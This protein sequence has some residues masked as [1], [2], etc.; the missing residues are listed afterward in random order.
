MIDALEQKIKTHWAVFR[1]GDGSPVAKLCFTKFCQRIV[2]EHTKVLFLV[3]YK[4]KPLCVLKI[5][6]S[7]SFNE[8]LK[9]EAT[10]QKELLGEGVSTISNV[11][12]EDN[13]DGRYLYAEEV[14]DGVPLSKKQAF[15]K[16]KE[17]VE[18]IASFPS[19][20]EITITAAAE[21]FEK[22]LPEGDERVTQ[23]LQELQ[24]TPVVL[25]TGLTHSD[26][27]RPNILYRRGQ[28]HIIDWERAGDRPFY[29]IDAVYFMIKL[30]RISGSDDW[31]KRA[32][33]IF[34]RY[35]GL[36][37]KTANALYCIQ[38]LFH[39]TYKH[40]PDVYQKLIAAFTSH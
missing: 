21:I 22:H 26:F 12:F 23:L 7:N 19:S 25:K 27:G 11:L 13:I 34:M 33:P 17:I 8:K 5:M 29:L 3:T 36:D 39:H 35:T 38:S 30:R 9:K 18:L 10:A 6:R 2:Q 14:V 4:D 37:E 40:H 20:G 1:T 28:F 31:K 16:E 32:L 15:K 24:S